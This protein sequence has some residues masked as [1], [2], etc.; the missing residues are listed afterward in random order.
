[1]ITKRC[2]NLYAGGAKRVFHLQTNSLT[3]HSIRVYAGGAARYCPLASGT[4]TNCINIRI[5]GANYHTVDYVPTVRFTY[6]AYWDSQP[7]QNPYVI[8]SMSVQMLNSVT[9]NKPV[10]IYLKVSNSYGQGS[11]TNVLSLPA[12]S[13]S[14]S[15]GNSYR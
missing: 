8:Y 12:N 7:Y 4:A 10:Y 1:M 11:W 15:T 2:L 3:T 13:V 9:I 5:G 6:R 14:A